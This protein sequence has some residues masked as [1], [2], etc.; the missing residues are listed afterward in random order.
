MHNCNCIPDTELKM[1]LSG[2]RRRTKQDQNK[3]KRNA[4]LQ[5]AN[6]KLE[7]DA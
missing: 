3:T 5:T 7:R 2:A 1:L 6:C 4:Q